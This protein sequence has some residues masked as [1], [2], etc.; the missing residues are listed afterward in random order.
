MEIEYPDGEND[1]AKDT[2][3]VLRRQGIIKELVIGE[4]PI[5]TGCSMC[6]TRGM[7]DKLLA[8]GMDPIEPLGYFIIRGHRKVMISP[9]TL[10][11]NTAHVLYRGDNFP[12]E[13]VFVAPKSFVGLTVQV[14]SVAELGITDKKVWKRTRSR[15]RFI[16]RFCHQ[17]PRVRT[18]AL[19]YHHHNG[20]KCTVIVRTDDVRSDNDVF[21][22]TFPCD[23]RL[24]PPRPARVWSRE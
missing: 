3:V 7:G 11:P 20:F 5:L 9:E 12:E 17:P 14:Q 23:H 8:F 4:L 22:F 18:G 16:P 10:A 2:P 21:P 6:H 15:C 13:S 1:D 24:I 19:P